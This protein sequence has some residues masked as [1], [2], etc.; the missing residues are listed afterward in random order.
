MNS[1]SKSSPQNPLPTWLLKRVLLSLLPVI[2]EIVRLSLLHGQPIIYKFAL[3]TP[4]IKMPNIDKNNLGN[5]RPVSNL[6]FLSNLSF[7][8]QQHHLDN[9][10]H[11]A[12]QSAYK[13]L[14]SCE[15]ALLYVHSHIIS[16]MDQRKLSLMAMI[17]LSAAFDTMSHHRLLK[18][19]ESYGIVGLALHWFEQYLTERMQAVQV[20]Q[21]Q[22]DVIPL[23][24]GVP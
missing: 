17:D 20:K 13:A 1:P 5:Y 7:R 6:S 18:K 10:L 9:N 12:H 15:T 2:A 23:T 24:T 21:S 4:I 19:L 8:L 14:H 16:S 22:S 11:N 3:L